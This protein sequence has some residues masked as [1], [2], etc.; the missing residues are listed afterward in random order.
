V[1][2]RQR[3][4]LDF[5]IALYYHGVK[6]HSLS[7][8]RRAIVNQVITRVW[9]SDA[10]EYVSKLRSQTLGSSSVLKSECR[11]NLVMAQKGLMLQQEPRGI[12]EFTLSDPVRGADIVS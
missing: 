1:N 5:S 9:T 6:F 7:I 10:A 8:I 4:V 2:H 3:F 11:L 12:V